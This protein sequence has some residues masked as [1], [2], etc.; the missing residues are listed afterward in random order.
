MSVIVRTPR[1]EIKLYCKGADS[2]IMER[3]GSNDENAQLTSEHLESFATEGLRTL[4][5]AYR[6][7]TTEEYE[8]NINTD[9]L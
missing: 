4:C 8:V 1:N 5:L 2:V 6:I 3:L 7:L 9:L